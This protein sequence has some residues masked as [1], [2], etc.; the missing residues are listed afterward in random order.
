MAQSFVI[1][2]PMEC[3]ECKR[4]NRPIEGKYV[5]L[6]GTIHQELFLVKATWHGVPFITPHIIS[7]NEV[8]NDG[9]IK[10]TVACGVVGC[11]WKVIKDDKGE[12]VPDCIKARAVLMTPEDWNALK[13]FN[14]PA[15]F[16]D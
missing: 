11:G 9:L 15:Y 4:L 1:C 5:F 14:D 3:P 7:F 10:I 6:Y 12:G 8:T 2:R 16:I 13:R